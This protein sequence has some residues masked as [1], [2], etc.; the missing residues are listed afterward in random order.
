MMADLD[1]LT[2]WKVVRGN[3]ITALRLEPEKPPVAS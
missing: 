3:A 1:D 2:V